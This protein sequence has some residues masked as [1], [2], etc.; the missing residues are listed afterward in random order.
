MSRERCATK[1][2]SDAQVANRLD[3]Y[4]QDTGFA[5]AHALIWPAL[6]N[7]IQTA[8]REQFDGPG[9]E[10]SRRLFEGRPDEH[11]VRRVAEIGQ[12][13]YA[14]GTSIPHWNVK[15]AAMTMAIMRAAR[16]KFSD[17]R[18][19]IGM[20]CDTVLTTM[21]YAADIILAQIAVCEAA[22]AAEQRGQH[23]ERFRMQVTEISATAAAKAKDM[24]NRANDSAIS[25]RG[26]LGKT[27]E[28][29]AAAEQSALAMREA[30]QT[31]AGLIRAIEDARTEVEGAANVATRA[32][33]Q[34]KNAVAV[35]EALSGHVETIESILGLIRDI[36]GQT[37][38][39]ALNAT[40]EAA[41]AGDAG[42]GFAVVAQ[43]VKSLA[44]QTAR[45]TDDIASKIA[46]ITDATRQTVDSNADIEKTVKE[47]EASA[48]R[49]RQAME[50]QAQTVTTITAAVDETAL[51]ADSMS[52]TITAIRHD[53]EAVANS[54]GGVE[55]DF[56]QFTHEIDRF[57]EASGDF[58]ANIAR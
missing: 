23:G 21:L 20:L 4:L 47:V 32:G 17:D 14:E 44:S 34:A 29:A 28:V 26:M 25:A 45:A 58:A 36:A 9:I 56:E 27:S 42:R 13:L 8:A 39:L 55:K 41:R 43:E 1:S 5:A 18:D 50:A 10:L 40:I 7:E 57:G 15:R 38:L 37:N 6:H 53:T 3:A 35:S 54:I 46:A 19:K 48:N 24:L 12:T 30:A 16:A 51:A 31:A 22:E 52:S 11:W 49:I 33:S 2:L